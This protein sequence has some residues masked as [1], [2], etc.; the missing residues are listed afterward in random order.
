ML[1][2]LIARWFDLLFSFHDV[3]GC[4]YFIY[5]S[6]LSVRMHLMYLYYSGFIRFFYIL[7]PESQC[8]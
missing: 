2:C 3:C 8:A 1:S 6:G 4:F 7:R 5:P